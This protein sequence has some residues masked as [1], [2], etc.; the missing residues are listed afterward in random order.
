MSRTAANFLTVKPLPNGRLLLTGSID[1]LNAETGVWQHKQIRERFRE[2][3]LADARKNELEA[4]AIAHNLATFNAERTVAT[5]LTPEQ[6]RDAEAAFAARG[7]RPW[8]LLECVQAAGT[9]LGG[10]KPILCVDAVRDYIADCEKVGFS[11]VS[12]AFKKARFASFLKSTKAQYLSEISSDD[13]DRY[14][15]VDGLAAVSKENRAKQLKAFFKWCMTRKTPLIG[16]S[17]CTIDME[18]MKHQKQKEAKPVSVLF[19]ADCAALFRAASTIDAGSHLPIVIF[20]LFAFMRM[21]EVRKLT[22]EDIARDGR[23]ANSVFVAPNKRGCKY[24]YAEVPANMMPALQ[25]CLASGII[26]KEGALYFSPKIW[27]RI[28]TEAGL[29]KKWDAHIMRHSGCS[30]FESM[31]HDLKEGNRQAGHSEDVAF[32]NYLYD[33]SEK[34]AKEFYAITLSPALLN[35]AKVA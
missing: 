29:S 2:A 30:Y 25:H 34:Q 18:A 22:R 20:G 15:Y 26:P 21:T 3:S 10:A 1:V 28:R 11:K 9:I 32:E 5:S 14:V 12:I 24:R 4:A 13:V 19:P 7:S 33:F 27:S 17:P 23:K 35:P 31:H 8:S 16:R 6:L